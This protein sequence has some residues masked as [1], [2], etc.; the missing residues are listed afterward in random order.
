[1]VRAAEHGGD[2]AAGAGEE[3]SCLVCMQIMKD[4]SLTSSLISTTRTIDPTALS[5]SLPL[6]FFPYFLL[7]K[8]LC[9]TLTT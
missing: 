4:A 9:P 1:M 2:P 8:A 5:F 3:F 6:N 7:N